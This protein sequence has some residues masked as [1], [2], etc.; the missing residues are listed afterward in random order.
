MRKQIG[1]TQGKILSPLLQ[2]A[3]PV[4]VALILQT[5]YGAVDLLVIGQFCGAADV[6]AV[7]TGSQILQM[8]TVLVTGLAMGTTVLLGQKLGQG[9]EEG[10]G[11]TIGTSIVLFG[12]VGV[13]ITII[14]VVFAKVFAIWT[15]APSEALAATTDYV[16]ICGGG[17]LFIVAYNVLGSVF[18]GIGDSKTPLI[19]VAIAC[20]ANVVLD[21][22]FVAVFGMGVAGVALATALAQLISVILSVVII[23]KRGLP[24]ALHKKQIRIQKPVMLKTLRLGAPVAFQ[25]FLVSCSFMVI[26]AIVNV[27]GVVPSAGVGVAER[28]CGFIMLIP[29]AFMQSISAFVAQNIGAGEPLRAKRAMQ[30]GMITSFVIGLLLAYAGYF[31]GDLLASVF[32]RDK[33]VIAQ[34]ADYLKAYSID[35]LLVSFLFCFIGY[36]N[37]CGET[38][39]VMVQGIVGAFG[40]R[41]PVSYLMSRLPQ[42]SL[43]LIGLATPCSTLVQIILCIVWMARMEKRSQRKDVTQLA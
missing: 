4:L 6:S 15:H 17:A 22:L 30:Y 29:S 7:S 34:A 8:V 9:D 12:I 39:F 23:R 25:D 28:L 18:R 5:M 35:T 20:A 27:L 10:A 32:A 38:N 19:A 36:F 37:G 43:F 41:I 11:D 40:V 14:L 1:F 16:R 2:F 21:L 33:A 3:F 24:F 13:V 31:H 42:T 26:I